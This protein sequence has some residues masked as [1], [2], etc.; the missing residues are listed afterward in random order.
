MDIEAA[1]KY[2]HGI[3]RTN[4]I[5]MHQFEH[6]QPP[7]VPAQGRPTSPTREAC[8]D[9]SSF[10]SWGAGGVDEGSA[11]MPRPRRPLFSL[12]CVFLK[13]RCRERPISYDWVTTHLSY[14][15]SEI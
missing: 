3:D 13:R 8:S 10:G 15:A 7:A 5:A 2:E 4:I 1:G 9:Q 6:L 11:S 12:T 14:Q